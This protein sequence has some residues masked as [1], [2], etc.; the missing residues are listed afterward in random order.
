MKSNAFPIGTFTNDEFALVFTADGK[1]FVKRED[2][3]LVEAIYKISG[4]KILIT[5]TGGERACLSPETADGEYE[6]T[7]DGA[8]L[9]FVK[10]ED[11]CEGRITSLTTQPLVFRDV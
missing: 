2:K 10:T 11:L 8:E 6:W 3:T 1:L 4:D 7:F 5:D 9:N